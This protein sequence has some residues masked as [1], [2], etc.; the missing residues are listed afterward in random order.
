MLP[1][2]FQRPFQS[3]KSDTPLDS[4]I[5][6]MSSLTLENLQVTTSKEQL[7]AAQQTTTTKEDEQVGI[8]KH[9]L[10]NHNIEKK[11]RTG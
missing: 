6:E 4:L 1:I 2:V 9:S 3:K 7:F 8:D 10:S 11:D 5:K